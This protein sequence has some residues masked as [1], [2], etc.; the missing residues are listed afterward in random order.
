M[1]LYVLRD[2]LAN[3]ILL[4]L[5]VVDG[6]RANILQHLQPRPLHFFSPP[7]AVPKAW[8]FK[9]FTWLLML[10]AT[11]FTYLKSLPG[12]FL[13][14]GVIL[15]VSSLFLTALTN[16]LSAPN[17][18]MTRMLSSLTSFLSLTEMSLTELRTLLVIYR[19]I[20]SG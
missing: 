20:F 4:E 2:P 8:C 9:L 17:V 15:N 3:L 12:M 19:T 1:M 10:G 14:L 6:A 5:I 13:K 7:F 11:F 16:L 18:E